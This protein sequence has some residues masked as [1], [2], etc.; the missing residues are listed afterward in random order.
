MNRT[1]DYLRYAAEK[2]RSTGQPFFIG[3]GYRKPH[4]PWEA[5]QEAWDLYNNTTIDTAAYDVFSNNTDLIAWS[6]QLT[7][8]LSNGTSFPFGPYSPVPK[9]V[10]QDQRRAY[11]ASIS[12]FDSNV[13]Q[14]LTLLKE[15]ELENDTM[16]V[17]HA[18]HGYLLGEY[19]YCKWAIESPRLFLHTSCSDILIH[20]A[21][22]IP[23]L[24]RRGKKVQ[25]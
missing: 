4:A 2:F 16:V 1:R 14:L 25:L 6:K 18:D 9:W 15:L 7:V 19:G 3:S 10:Q 12:F 8:E 11:Y 23:S 22:I 24:L 17:V 21:E 13:G 5:P 20:I